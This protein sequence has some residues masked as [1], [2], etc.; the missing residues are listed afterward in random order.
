MDLQSTQRIHVAPQGYEEERI[1]RPAIKY[2]ADKVILLV[3]EGDEQ[4]DECQQ[5]V[6]EKLES[7]G[8]EHET[9]Q[10]DIFDQDESVQTISGIIQQHSGDDVF[11]NISTGSKITAITG[12]LACMLTD[13]VPYYVK[14]EHYG[15]EPVSKGIDETIELPAYPID[16]P[17]QDFVQVLSYLEDKDEDEEVVMQDLNQYINEENLE[18][19]S[20]RDRE[21]GSNIY[22]V[23]GPEIIEPLQDRSL[24][25]V[26]NYMGKKHIKITEKGKRTLEFS[27]HIIKS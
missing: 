10:C 24:I 13:G 27:R 3:T 12:M 8:I 5:N 25:N 26:Q 4:A 19:V 9:K 1:Y 14:A 7:A 2:D 16:A 21:D 18:I 15:D 23:V 22:D 11:V 6:E 17:K 20:D